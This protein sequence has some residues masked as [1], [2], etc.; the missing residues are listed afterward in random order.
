MHQPYLGFFSRILSVSL[1]DSSHFDNLSGSLLRVTLLQK[2]KPPQLELFTVYKFVGWLRSSFTAVLSCVVCGFLPK[3]PNLR[4]GRG[5]GVSGKEAGLN[6]LCR[7]TFPPRNDV[8]SAALQ[9][10]RLSLNCHWHSVRARAAPRRT[11]VIVSTFR[12]QI[13]FCLRANPDRRSHSSDTL[14][15]RPTSLDAARDLWIKKYIYKI[16]WPLLPLIQIHVFMLP[17]NCLI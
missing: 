7:K 9:F 8:T 6:L 1:N 16:Y 14:G 3:L 4:K 12:R 13:F 10:H 2:W 17:L 5:G 15:R 11:A